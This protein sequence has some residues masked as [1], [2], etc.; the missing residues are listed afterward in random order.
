MPRLLLLAFIDQ[1][2]FKVSQTIS[3]HM[4]IYQGISSAEDFGERSMFI[5]LEI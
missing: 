4:K 3:D 2:I 1:S 5:S